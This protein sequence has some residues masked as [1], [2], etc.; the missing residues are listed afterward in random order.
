MFQLLKLG[1]C[2]EQARMVLPQNMIT[3]FYWSGS[4]DAFAKMCKLRRSNDAQTE[5]RRIAIDI[6]VD[7][8]TIYPPSWEALQ[9][10]LNY[11]VG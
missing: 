8:N 2:E 5:N 11:C 7:M 10:A 1:V 3:D 9:E 6:A 4:L